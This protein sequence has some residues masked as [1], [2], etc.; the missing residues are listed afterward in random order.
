MDLILQPMIL[1]HQA[2]VLHL[3]RN[4]DIHVLDNLNFAESKV[5]IMYTIRTAL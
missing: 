4:E 2:S 1:K 3:K 5:V